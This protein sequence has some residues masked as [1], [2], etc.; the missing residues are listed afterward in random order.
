MQ[1]LVATTNSNKIREIRPLLAGLSLDVLTLQDLAGVDSPDEVATSYWEN[2]RLKA[3]AYARAARERGY[4]TDLVVVA[5]DSGL[6]IRGMNGAPGVHSA[7][8]LGNGVPYADRF[9]AIYQRLDGLPPDA[10]EARFVTALA[11]VRDR[12]VL[13]ESEAAIDGII[14]HTPAGEHGFGYDPIFFYEPLRKTTA[15][16]TLDEKCL[17]SH[18]A[19]AVRD[20]ARWLRHSKLA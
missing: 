2:A 10:R 18:R 5:E 9:A 20:F 3:F 19:R 7:R 4:A 15:E 11:A 8:F 1:L 14:N 17:V 6:E 16:M 13:F 12:E